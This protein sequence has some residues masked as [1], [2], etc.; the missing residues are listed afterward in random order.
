M[1]LLMRDSDNPGDIPLDDLAAVAGYADGRPQWKSEDWKR[2]EGRGIVPLSIVLSADHQGDILDVEGGAA[3]PED[4]PG[5]ADRFNRPGRRAPTIYCDRSTIDAVRREM[6]TRQFDLWVAT[7]DG[8]KHV[9]GA[10]AVQYCGAADSTNQC[11]TSGHYDESVILDEDWLG[12]DRREHPSRTG[13]EGTMIILHHPSVAGRLDVLVVDSK[14]HCAHTV[15]EHGAGQL[16]HIERWEDLGALP[17][18]RIASGT[19]G[20]CWDDLTRL[21]IIASDQ[22]GQGFMKVLQNSGVIDEE[23]SPINAVVT[24]PAQR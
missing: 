20:V 19:L 13:S 24:P 4:C 14:G 3:S 5:W 23:W 11:R 22:N 21:C 12:V 18:G 6:G 8:T 7:L 10:V 17:T 16:N 15:A 1:T 9:D 2:F